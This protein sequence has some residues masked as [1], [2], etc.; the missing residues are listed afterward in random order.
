MTFKTMTLDISKR[1]IT[2]SFDSVEN[3]QAYEEELDRK[4]NGGKAMEL[5]HFETKK[6]H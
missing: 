4:Q 5:S 2:Q 3:L 1:P 6:L